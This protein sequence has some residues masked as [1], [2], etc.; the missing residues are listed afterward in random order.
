M[1]VARLRSIPKLMAESRIALKRMIEKA[2]SMGANAVVSVRIAASMI[3]SG[4]AETVY[5]GITV[6]IGKRGV[7]TVF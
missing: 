2:R 5:Y 3:A 7:I 1:L 6:V 4:V